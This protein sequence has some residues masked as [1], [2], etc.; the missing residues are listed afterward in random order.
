[1]EIEEAMKYVLN[2][3]FG[4]EVSV[5][6]EVVAGSNL[7][8]NG[9][10]IDGIR[11]AY[12]GEIELNAGSYDAGD[13]VIKLVSNTSNIFGVRIENLQGAGVENVNAATKAV[14]TFENG[15]LVIIKN[16]VRYNALGAK[17]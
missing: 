3:A 5:Y 2:G 9:K 12:A 16:G 8:G 14:K 11:P 1:M 6:G 7:T 10:K 4:V 17:L 15:Q 13:V